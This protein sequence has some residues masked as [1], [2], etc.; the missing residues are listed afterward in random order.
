MVGVDD[1]N[2]R[3]SLDSVRRI[4]VGR[5]IE[6]LVGVFRIVEIVGE[7]KLVFL[8]YVPVESGQRGRVPNGMLDGLA[9]VLPHASLQEVQERDSLAFR[10]AVYYGI[11]DSHHGIRYGARRSERRAQIGAGQ[12]RENLFKGSENE[13]LVLHDGPAHRAAKLVAAEIGQGLSVGGR[14]G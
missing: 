11:I 9:V 6:G 8:I 2:L 7:R 12:L 4:A 14:G 13:H 1:V 10:A 3:R 5:H